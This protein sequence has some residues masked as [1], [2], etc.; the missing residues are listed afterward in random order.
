MSNL[1]TNNR[2]N[3]TTSCGSADE[4]APQGGSKFIML[5]LVAAVVAA[6]AGLTVLRTGAADS[7]T[8]PTITSKP[9]KP[10][11]M[12]QIRG[13]CLQVQSGDDT[14]PFPKYIGEIA[15]TGAN[16]ICMSV[17]AFQQNC[18]SSS[19]FIDARKNPS[20]KRMKE[21][22]DEA[23]KK[24]MKI[25][26]MPIV[27]L[28]NPRDGEW[29]G[30]IDPT[31]DKNSWDEW[32]ESYTNYILHYA[33]IAE[34]SKVEIFMVGSELVST[35]SQTERWVKLIEQVRK[36]YSGKL[37]Y[38]S[39]WDHYKPVKYWDKL[40]IVG[41]TTYYDL[42]GDQKPTMDVLLATWKGIKKEILD[43]QATVNRPILFTEV[44]WPN[45]ET[46]ARYP[47]DYYRA[48]DKPA[49]ELQKLCFEAFFK[50]WAD[51]KALAGYL[52]WEWRNYD[53]YEIGPKDTG[54][55]PMNKPAMEVISK[56]FKLPNGKQALTA[57]APAASMPAE[58]T[59]S[60]PT[61]KPADGES[62]AIL[63]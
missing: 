23:H 37:S 54:Y 21:L 20:S 40:D 59:A 18:G 13:V 52:V 4:R 46:A 27:L 42:C 31:K 47:W 62:T 16:T 33:Q 36:V 22:F 49:P 56:H 29:R 48:M 57:T 61:S 3:S 17:A 34:E 5:G 38:S 58:P 26:L 55:C 8:Q 28:E 30:K 51:E 45:Q 7:A 53:Q 44:G 14:H 63:D 1:D 9:V 6:V 10:L 25:V 12:E 60:M 39:N 35:E 19:I 32:W 2:E 15:D 11:D 24:G 41:M 43:W 50:A